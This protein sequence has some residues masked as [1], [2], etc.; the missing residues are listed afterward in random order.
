MAELGRGDRSPK[1]FWLQKWRLWDTPAGLRGYVLAVD[2]AAVGLAVGLLVNAFVATPATDSAWGRFV[3]L[4]AL[5]VTFEEVSLRVESLRFRLREYRHKDMTSV[6]TFAAAIVL[7]LGL[8]VLVVVVLRTYIWLRSERRKNAVPFRIFFSAAT[9]LLACV[10]ARKVVVET[11]HLLGASSSGLSYLLAVCAGMVIYT[12]VN[13][14]LVHGAIWLT[15]YPVKPA[16][17]FR[18]GEYDLLEVAT[19]C[20]AALTA[21][22]LRFEPWLAVLVLPTM[23]VLNRTALLKELEV[24]ATTDAKTGLLNAVAWRQLAGRELSRAQR[25]Q[26]SAAMLIVDMDNFKLINDTYGH[27]V[28]DAVL[29]AV[30]DSLAL[31]LRGYDT[32]GRFGGEE[33]VALLADVHPVQALDVADRVLR[34][35]RALQVPTRDS[36]GS[37][38]AGLSASIGLASYPEQGDDVEELLHIADSALYTAKREGRDRVEYS[39][40]ADPDVR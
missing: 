13:A 28:G 38:V 11:S 25:D 27:L 9:I 33:F 17:L 10:A 4:V 6:W 22:A 3:L 18:G 35:I 21:L 31:E 36:D 29:K 23:V 16:R 19:L 40:S 32:V 8:V 24:A 15:L 14:G 39:Y 12:L 20:L 5:A 1:V 34:A 2:F 37:I 7:P 26:R 30:A